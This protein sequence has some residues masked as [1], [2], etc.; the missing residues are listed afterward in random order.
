MDSLQQVKQKRCIQ[1]VRSASLPSKAGLLNMQT[2]YVLGIHK[3]RGLQ[4]VFWKNVL[5]DISEE[6]LEKWSWEKSETF[7]LYI[8][9]AFS[10][11]IKF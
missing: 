7:G 11:L 4:N 5:V 10:I 2:K 9:F 8:C 1:R 3:N 6:A